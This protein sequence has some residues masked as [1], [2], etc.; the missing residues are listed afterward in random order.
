MPNIYSQFKDL[1]PDNPILVGTVVFIGTGYV[2]V[3][4]LDGTVETCRGAGS[5]GTKVFVRA[6]VVEG[7]AP[8]LPTVTIEV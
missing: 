4:Y 1:L 2:M 8:T 6:G 5:I 7:V 3:E